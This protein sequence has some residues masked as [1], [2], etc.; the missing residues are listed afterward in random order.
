MDLI[1]HTIFFVNVVL[2][3]TLVRQLILYVCVKLIQVW[4]LYTITLFALFQDMMLVACGRPGFYLLTFLQFAY[5]FIGEFKSLYIVYDSVISLT[6]CY[7]N[8]YKPN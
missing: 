7:T 2:A 3:N 1:Y 5:P 8:K 4:L 6:H